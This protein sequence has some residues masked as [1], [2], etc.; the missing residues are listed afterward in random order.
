MLNSEPIQHKS[1]ISLEAAYA[2][3]ERVARHYENFPVGSMLVP[4]KMRKHFYALYSFMRTADDFA[5][6]R[7][8]TEGIKLLEDWRYQ[9]QQV[10]SSERAEHPIF[11]ALRNTISECHLAGE[12]LLLLLEAFEFD[13]RG[14]VQ[15][16]TFDDLRWYTSRSADPVG[17]LVLALFSY[18]DEKLIR[19]SNE[20]CTALQLLNFIQDIREDL[21]NNRY[22]YPKDDW[23]LFGL[24]QTKQI[25]SKP[26]LLQRLNLLS[27][28]EL[29]RV[30]SLLERGAPLINQVSGRLRLEL[31]AIVKSARKL[32]KKIRKLEGNTYLTRP[33]LS[34]G[35]RLV[36]LL[37]S[38]LWIG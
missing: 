24:D 9:L 10:L 32:A 15:F 27:L 12:P 36:V 33:T 11:I 19:L 21:A 26:L 28:F 34:K 2:E 7:G 1:E 18:H 38:V 16:D 20:I 35:E 37:Q 8:S 22:Y 6:T 17:E 14:K 13:A 23:L 5:D 29:E 30:E 4:K 3:C 25:E 31:R